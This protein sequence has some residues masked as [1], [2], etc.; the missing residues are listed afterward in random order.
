MIKNVTV[1]QLGNLVGRVDH[2][3]R[4]ALAV[5]RVR[6]PS[7]R[8]RRSSKANRIQPTA[9]GVDGLPEPMRWTIESCTSDSTQ[10]RGSYSQHE[11]SAQC[12]PRLP[13]HPFGAP[14]I[15]RAEL[16]AVEVSLGSLVDSRFKKCQ[17]ERRK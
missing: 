6:E 2:E 1:T 13:M 12:E 14:S 9:N 17:E 8:G 11:S 10:H 7:T 4:M 5:S 3:R 15:A 16:P